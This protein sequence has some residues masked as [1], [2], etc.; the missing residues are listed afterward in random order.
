MTKFNITEFDLIFLSYDEPNAEY[1]FSD[2]LEKAPWA[3]RVHGIKGFN[4][5]H[6]A[7]AEMAQTDWFVTVD[8]D[9][10]VRSEFFD[11]QVEFD[12]RHEPL[13]CF[14]WNGLNAINGLA[15]G[16][17][18][19]KLWSKEF[20]RTMR[21]HEHADNPRKAVDF[22]WERHYRQMYQTY[23]DV[24]NNGSPYQAFRVGFREGVKLALD[25][26][27][28]VSAEMMRFLHPVNLRNLRI[29]ACVGAHIEN[30]L[31][32]MLGTRLALTRMCDQL[33]NHTVVRDYDWFRH[34]WEEAKTYDTVMM[35]E[36]LGAKLMQQ[37]KIALPVLEDEQSQF[38][39][40]VMAQRNE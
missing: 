17:G 31:W 13:C 39:R 37:T 2:L 34:F 23:S 33:W 4:S 29:W 32:A 16:N 40:E 5:A 8:A 36:E 25:R 7:C 20:V 30:G 19:L 11:V 15:Y 18:G 3:Q 38:F 6:L 24:W 26:G 22:C 21:S 10:I 14:S 27:E 12:P 28:R 9:N 35:C 1:N